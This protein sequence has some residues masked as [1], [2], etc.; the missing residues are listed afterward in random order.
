MRGLAV[1]LLRLAEYYVLYLMVAAA[2]VWDL[3]SPRVRGHRASVLFLIVPSYLLLWKYRRVSLQSSKI[4]S[5]PYV[6]RYIFIC[7]IFILVMLFSGT[8][9][10]S[11]IYEVIDF[12]KGS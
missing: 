9:I 3:W 2:V 12:L 7:G 10:I 11:R 4:R 1:R 5:Q 8:W 6:L